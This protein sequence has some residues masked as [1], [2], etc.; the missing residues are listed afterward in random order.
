MS[1]TS[2]TDTDAAYQGDDAILKVL[3]SHQYLKDF[4]SQYHADK[5][6]RA[7][8]D[9]G[10]LSP[11][12]GQLGLDEYP[13]MEFRVAPSTAEVYYFLMPPDPS[14]VLSDEDVSGITG[15]VG[16]TASSAGSV[17]TAGSMIT[18][19]TPSTFSSASS[20]GSAGT[21]APS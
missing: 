8:V 1:D 16:T 4:A 13:N 2:T 17:G 21:A 14:T 10:D 3:V 18:I 11:I 9:G 19:T 12:A 7:Q 20:A 5:A 15:G 6:L